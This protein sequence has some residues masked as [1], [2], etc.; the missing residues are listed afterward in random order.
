MLQRFM[1]NHKLISGGPKGPSHG[2]KGEQEEASPPTGERLNNYHKVTQICRAPIAPK[3]LAKATPKELSRHAQEEN[4]SKI[5]ANP[6]QRTKAI[7]RV[8][9]LQHFREPDGRRP[10][11]SCHR[12]IRISSGVRMAQSSAT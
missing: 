6:A 12:K 9:P 1:N 4:I 3:G 8:I 11:V 5:L 2:C 10:W 7:F